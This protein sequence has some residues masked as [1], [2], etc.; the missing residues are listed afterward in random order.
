MKFFDLPIMNDSTLL[1]GRNLTQTKT[2]FFEIE[3]ENYKIEV[4]CPEGQHL[5]IQE[6]LYS[7]I[8]NNEEKIQRIFS[9]KKKIILYH[10]TQ[11][12]EHL[13]KLHLINY[14]ENGFT[15]YSLIDFLE[16]IDGYT[17]ISLI[18]W[19]YF[20]GK[21]DFSVL[22]SKP[23]VTIKRVT[24]WIY[25]LILIIITLPITILTAICIRLESSG[26]I[27][28]T[29]VRVG[30][31]NKE[32]KV[33]KFRSMTVDAEN[34]G[35]QWAQKSDPRT[36][37]VGKFIRRTR[38]DEIPQLINVLRGEMSLIGPRPERMVFIEML[39]NNIPFYEFRHS[40]L[41]GI[42]GWA[43]V[44]YPYG[45]SVQDGIWKHKYDLY[46]IKNQSF[47]FDLKIILLTIRAVLLG[48][49]R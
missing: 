24:D 23:K 19:D 34:K 25:A 41:P 44:K 17:D 29:Q 10:Q 36:T 18:N 5:Q 39:V 16:K 49:G 21:N 32:F 13:D 35:A 1:Y 4:F 46:Y 20:I 38:I 31:F 12:I 28:Y 7:R 6:I 8:V 15:A 42:T 37:K 47:L 22:R 11:L 27:F 26:P 33:I 9:R 30:Q 48:L 45:A 14:I 43:Q 40:I 3:M 2:S